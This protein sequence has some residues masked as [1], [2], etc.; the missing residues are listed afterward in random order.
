MK[1]KLITAPLLFYPDY[2][3]SFVVYTDASS[4][5]IGAILAQIDD[6]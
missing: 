2:E 4:E 6:D 3:K 1:E 5:A